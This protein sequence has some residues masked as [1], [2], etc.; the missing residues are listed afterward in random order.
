MIIKGSYFFVNPNQKCYEISSNF[1]NYLEIGT[2]NVTAYYLEAKI[3]EDSF[4]ISGKLLNHNGEILCTLEDN[5]IETRRGCIKEMTKCGYRIKNNQGTQIFE[6]NVENNICHLQ[7]I[8]YSDSGEK[9]A[10]GNKITFLIFKG[11]AII[12]K[13]NNSVGLKLG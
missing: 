12:G 13:K 2:K 10:E 1:A 6:I 5:F 9:V 8:I 11:P 3:E 4:K 7:G